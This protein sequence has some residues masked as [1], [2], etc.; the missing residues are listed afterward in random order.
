MR[1]DEN[2]CLSESPDKL[3]A[4]YLSYLEKR[5]RNL[6][7][8]YDRYDQLFD[9]Y[10]PELVNISCCPAHPPIDRWTHGSSSSSWRPDF[11]VHDVILSLALARD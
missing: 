6:S 10:P 3:S 2:E 1:E 11:I 8:A 4:R 7:D 9:K 5:F